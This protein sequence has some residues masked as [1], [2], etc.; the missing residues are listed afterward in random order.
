RGYSGRSRRCTGG[1]WAV[2][3]AELL[4][5]TGC[6]M[7]TTIL[8]GLLA[9]LPSPTNFVRADEADFSLT[10]RS[11]VEKAGGYAVTTRT[12]A[13]PARKTAVI[14]CD[15][16]DAHHCLNAV[17]R[18]NEMVPRMEEFLKK[19]RSR[20]AFIIHAPSSCMAA[21][22]DHPARKRAQAAPAARNLP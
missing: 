16:W 8:A 2:H 17:R 19:A 4:S 21:Y 6:V 5:P 1:P 18:E 10:L 3:R 22:Q 7:R 9:F 12:E 11:R 13:W 14:V 20:G 15:M